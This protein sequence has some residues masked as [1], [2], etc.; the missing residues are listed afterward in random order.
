MCADRATCASVTD[1]AGVPTTEMTLSSISQVLGG[2]L[3]EVAGDGEDLLLQQDRGVVDRGADHRAAA[4]PAGA[5]TVRRGFGVALVDGDVVDVHAEVLGRELGGG[6]LETLA[7]RPRRDV[8]VDAAVG[9]DAQMRGL[10]AVRAEV[11]LRLDV[12]REPDAQEA[13]VGACAGLLGAEG[14]VP[15]RVDTLLERLLGRHVVDELA[16]GRRVRKLGSVQH[17]A[18]AQLDGVHP[19][20][21]RAT[22]STISSRATVSII[23]GPRYAAL[24]QVLVH[25]CVVWKPSCG[26]RYGPRE[27]RARQHARA[28]T[29]DRVSAGV[30]DVID[31]RAD[32][33]SVV[34]DRHRDRHLLDARVRGRDEMLMAILD[35]F[36]RSR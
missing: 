3:E 18:A 21:A 8:H 36:D 22:T 17:V 14:V 24:P 11:R 25:T 27:Q 4:A 23:H 35:P 16:T 9:R 34:V 33:V 7:V 20:R 15:D 31:V 29:A 12:E 28:P 6:G 1:L 13:S 32:E 10:V 2:G 26:T 5:R 19:D 30:V